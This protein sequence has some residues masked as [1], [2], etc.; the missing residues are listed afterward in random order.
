MGEYFDEPKPKEDETEEKLITNFNSLLAAYDI[1][2]N[3][4]Q[5]VTNEGYD[6]MLPIRVEL[7][8]SRKSPDDIGQVGKLRRKIETSRIWR[9]ELGM[10]MYSALKNIEDLDK[11]S[12][13]YGTYLEENMDGLKLI[14]KSAF[15]MIIDLDKQVANSQARIRTMEDQMVIQTVPI[16]K[17]VIPA[18]IAPP[19]EIESYDERVEQQELKNVVEEPKSQPE[20]GNTRKITAVERRRNEKINA[21]VDAEFKKR[22]TEKLADYIEAEKT[23]DATK[24]RMAKMHVLGIH[25]ISVER[26]KFAED[27]LAKVMLKEVEHQ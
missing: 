20:A 27:E 23:G 16:P 24:M 9:M 6:A 13:R 15:K 19:T 21:P 1:L 26:K 18:K 22:L 8:G 4:I 5:T 12:E 2:V 10:D 17:K 14:C 7:M 11:W 25:G 3:K